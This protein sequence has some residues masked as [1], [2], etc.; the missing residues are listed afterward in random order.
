MTIWKPD[1][2]RSEINVFVHVDR[3]QP[4]FLIVLFARESGLDKIAVS[5]LLVRFGI[6]LCV[7]GVF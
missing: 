1:S 2:I 3:V 5:I 4:F 6:A 7:T